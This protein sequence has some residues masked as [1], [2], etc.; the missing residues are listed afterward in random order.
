MNEY[1]HLLQAKSF[2]HVICQPAW[3]PVREA[4]LIAGKGLLSR[5]LQHVFLDIISLDA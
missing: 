2:F 3:P 4:T 1:L 5:M